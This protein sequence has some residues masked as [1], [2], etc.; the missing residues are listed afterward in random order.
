MPGT[1]GAAAA[2]SGRVWMVSDKP[3]SDNN[4]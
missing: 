2:P 1:S 4:Q 3:D